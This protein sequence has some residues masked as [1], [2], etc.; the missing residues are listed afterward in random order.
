[1]E[2]MVQSCEERIIFFYYIGN[3]LVKT[4]ATNF[5]FQRPPVIGLS[6]SEKFNCVFKLPQ[7][8]AG[9]E[10]RIVFNI[11]KYFKFFEECRLLC[12]IENSSATVEELSSENSLSSPDRNS[13]LNPESSPDPIPNPDRDPDPTSNPDLNPDPTSYPDLNPDPTPNP[14]LNPDPT[15]N[16]DLNPDPTPNPDLNPEGQ[17]SLENLPPCLSPLDSVLSEPDSCNTLNI[18]PP[19]LTP[20]DDD[21]PLDS[22]IS[23]VSSN[24]SQIEDKI[25]YASFCIQNNILTLKKPNIRRHK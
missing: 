18:S 8:F 3:T 7:S 10:N 4:F 22:L 14:D 20:I 5:K 17:I 15:P 16:P 19:N 6:I 24:A 2:N 25:E 1:M 21:I 23:K 9:R 12:P 13:D 11:F